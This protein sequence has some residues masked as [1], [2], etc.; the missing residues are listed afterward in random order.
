MIQEKRVSMLEE[1]KAMADRHGVPAGA[2]L[3][4]HSA[5]GFDNSHQRA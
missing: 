2:H 5:T 4:A 3:A 1:V